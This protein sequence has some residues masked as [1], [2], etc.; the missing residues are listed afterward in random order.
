MNHLSCWLASC[1]LLASSCRPVEA[2]RTGEAPMRTF[3]LSLSRV[4]QT[5]YRRLTAHAWLSSGTFWATLLLCLTFYTSALVG[6]AL[7]F[8][9]SL[10]YFVWPP[11]VVLLVA[12]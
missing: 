12:L 9:N 5:G 4:L 10:V 2:L 11:S 7:H 8:P 1:D 3:I 6:L